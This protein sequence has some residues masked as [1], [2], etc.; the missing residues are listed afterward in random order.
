MR[1]LGWSR[2]ADN[3]A[4]NIATM[5]TVDLLVGAGAVRNC[6]GYK[7]LNAELG[8]SISYNS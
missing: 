2:I 1:M 5:I 8:V 4:S 6:D 3:S 7:F